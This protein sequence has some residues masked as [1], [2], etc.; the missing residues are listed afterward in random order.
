ME[1]EVRSHRR[2]WRRAALASLPALGVTGLLGVLCIGLVQLAPS[3]G[4]GENT[5]PPPLFPGWGKPDLALVLSGQQHGYLQPCGCS[6]PQYGGFTRRYNL[7]QGLK[8]RG[9]PVV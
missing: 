6:D 5:P 3:G 9:W 7:V 2:R 4:P 1:K 8:E